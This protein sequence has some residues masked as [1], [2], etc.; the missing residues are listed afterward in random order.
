MQADMYNGRKKWCWWWYM[1]PVG[2]L[3]DEVDH[4]E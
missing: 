1:V 3:N 4:V 2:V